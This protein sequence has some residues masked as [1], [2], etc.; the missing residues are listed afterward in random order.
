MS[1]TLLQQHNIG[2]PSFEMCG[3]KTEARYEKDI[4]TIVCEIWTNIQTK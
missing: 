1:E 2:K 4:N 3:P